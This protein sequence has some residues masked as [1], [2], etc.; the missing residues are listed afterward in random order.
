[1]GVSRKRSST[2]NLWKNFNEN[3]D[4]LKP[5]F[6]TYYKC[7]HE[8][9]INFPTS[10]I[11]PVWVRVI[12]KRW[13]RRWCVFKQIA[14][15]I[16]FENVHTTCLALKNLENYL[17]FNFE[18]K[19]FVKKKKAQKCFFFL[20]SRFKNRLEHSLTDRSKISLID[21]YSLM[22][23]RCQTRICFLFSFINLFKWTLILILE[24]AEKL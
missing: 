7:K 19:S 2:L 23:N 21:L 11:G 14:K 16:Y 15:D 18:S 10:Q 22:L 1:M 20:H 12:F 17:Y 13:G 8:G 5:A 24:T 6:L 3:W 9:S 4:I